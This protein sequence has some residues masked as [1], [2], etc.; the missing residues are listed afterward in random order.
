MLWELIWEEEEQNEEGGRE[1]R[2]RAGCGE[3]G[4]DGARGRKRAEIPGFSK[5][6][7]P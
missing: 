4:K 6:V 3:E 7:I 2:K 5:L 1:R